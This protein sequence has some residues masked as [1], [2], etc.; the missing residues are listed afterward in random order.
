MAAHVNPAY[1]QHSA[2]ASG[3]WDAYVNPAYFQPGYAHHENFSTVHGRKGRHS[4]HHG[5]GMTKHHKAGVHARF[6]G[7]PMP[8]VR[9]PWRHMAEG[10]NKR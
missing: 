10:R 8:T 6:H 3:H 4:R 2:K 9:D 7:S 1:Y 5:R